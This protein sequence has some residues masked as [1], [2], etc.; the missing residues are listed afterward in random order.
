MAPPLCQPRQP[1][2][3]HDGSTA[4]TPDALLVDQGRAVVIKFEGDDDD[5]SSLWTRF[6]A[7]WLWAVDPNFIH[8]TSGQRMRSLSSLYSHK[9]QSISTS[10]SESMTDDDDDNAEKFPPRPSPGCLHSTGSVYQTPAHNSNG[11]DG[12]VDEN[13]ATRPMLNVVWETGTGDTYVSSYD[14]DW[15]RS[16]RYDKKT[17]EERTASTQ[18]TQHLALSRSNPL[19]EIDHGA[20]LFQH[21]SQSSALESDLEALRF[22]ILDALFRQGA[23]LLTN[24]HAGTTTGGND[25]GNQDLES[26]VAN[27]ATLLAKRI[28]HGHLYGDIFHVQH[29]PNANNIAYTSA[30]LAAHQDLAYYTAKPGLQ[31]LHCVNSNGTIGG[32]SL[33]VDGLAAATALRLVAPDLYQ[34]LLECEAT[35]V[36]QRGDADMVYRRPH[37]EQDSNGIVTAVHW[38]P[39]FEGPL[40]IAHDRVD[41]YFVAYTAYERMVDVLLPQDRYLLPA[42]DN[43]LEEQLMDYAREFTVERQL[44]EGDILIFNNHRMLHG[45]R[46]FE[47]QQQQQQDG[48]EAPTNGRHLVGCYTD[49]DETMNQYRLLRRSHLTNLGM[50][51]Y[52][53]NSGNGS[54]SIF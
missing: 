41:D 22:E 30:P 9:I 48:E 42:I 29:V 40:A 15:L 20:I 34:T 1:Q 33:L 18:I 14:M 27:L 39:P 38:S 13:K 43:A 8:P 51:E 10:I 16:R 45:R 53:P 24:N 32:E 19:V 6:H 4:A 50:T 52:I 12:D 23:V 28:S 44:Q 35:F 37:I 46:S 2:P 54:S 11:K 5:S 21:S 25:N 49:L 36:K 26:T 7:S 31:L 3:Q 47:V 17:M